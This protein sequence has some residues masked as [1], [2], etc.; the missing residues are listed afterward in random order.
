MVIDIYVQMSM[1]LPI[2]MISF[3]NIAVKDEKWDEEWTDFRIYGNYT[4]YQ[5]TP[6]KDGEQFPIYLTDST[7]VNHPLESRPGQTNNGVHSPIHV[8]DTTSDNPPQ[9]SGPG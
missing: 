5:A 2:S 7:S 3:F 9:E 6:Q 4:P 1:T 8:M